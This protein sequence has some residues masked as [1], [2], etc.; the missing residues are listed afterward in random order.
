MRFKTLISLVLMLFVGLALVAE[1]VPATTITPYITVDVGSGSAAMNT[2]FGAEVARLDATLD[3][4][5][6]F[7]NLA[8]INV[9][10]VVHEATEQMDLG[11]GVILNPG[12]FTYVYWFVVSDPFPGLNE[13][14]S[15][16]QI[17]AAA[18]IS[19]MVASESKVLGAGH[20]THADFG[21][22]PQEFPDP[23]DRTT[24]PAL[25]DQLDIVYPTALDPGSVGVSFIF[26]TS[27]T[28]YAQVGAL[29]FGLGGSAIGG[30]TFDNGIPIMIPA[31]GAATGSQVP[32]PA[33]GVGGLVLLALA[34][35]WRRLRSRLPR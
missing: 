10:T 3:A 31:D 13:S 6:T 23:T 7:A 35:G 30:S 34:G 11:G 16:F 33:A 21:G 27:D 18:G 9:I 26:T 32:T 25:Y 24:V 22:S 2:K 5:Y 17:L 19:E 8:H 28:H 15:E 14:M 4:G 1:Q 20:S 12:D 29:A